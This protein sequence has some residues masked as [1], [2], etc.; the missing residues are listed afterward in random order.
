MSAGPILY[1]VSELRPVMIKIDD[2]RR[3]FQLV[4]VGSRSKGLRIYNRLK[5]EEEVHHDNAC[6]FFISNGLSAGVKPRVDSS[7]H[8]GRVLTSGTKIYGSIYSQEKRKGL[9][10]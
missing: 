5:S 6:I 2:V 8:I 3:R 9:T 7:P 1:I 10:V 4:R